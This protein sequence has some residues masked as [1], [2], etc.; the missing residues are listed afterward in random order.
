MIL[1]PA[2]VVVSA[3]PLL[4]IPLIGEKRPSTREGTTTDHLEKAGLGKAHDQHEVRS[5]SIGP[6]E[7]D[8]Q[9]HDHN[10]QLPND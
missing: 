9:G 4:I 1:V 2:I 10:D 3:A 6:E 8:H 5:G 7:K